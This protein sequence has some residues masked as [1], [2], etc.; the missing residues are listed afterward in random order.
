M[1]DPDHPEPSPSLKRF[2]RAA[3][4]DVGVIGEVNVR[5]MSE[6]EMRR[7]N[8]DFRGKDKST[9]VLSFPA[10]QNE[11]TMTAGDIAISAK[12]ARANAKA[13][14]HSFE[15]ESKI[16]LLHGLLHLAGH[17]HESDDGEMSSLEQQLRAKLRLP[18]GLIERNKNHVDP[19]AAG[20]VFRRATKKAAVAKTVSS[21]TVS[22]GNGL[23][24]RST[25][26]PAR[27]GR[28]HIKARRS[29]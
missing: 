8:R 13:L 14:G 20:R 24:A 4:R 5:I 1:K 27:G 17:D 23:S 11:K 12:I 9:D 7:L 19:A 22:N 3:Q 6:A 2:L 18:T 21:A 10:I 16:L 15:E 29:S 25:K 26:H 28:G